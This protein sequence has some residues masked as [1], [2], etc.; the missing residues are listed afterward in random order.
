MISGTIVV[1]MEGE[2]RIAVSSLQ[3]VS[4]KHMQH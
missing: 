3:G 1:N 4:A 2:L